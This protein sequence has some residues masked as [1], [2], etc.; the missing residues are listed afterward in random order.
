MRQKTLT[1]HQKKALDEYFQFLK[2]YPYCASN[3]EL[4]PIIR[5]PDILKQY[6]AETGIVIGMAAQTPYVDFIVDLVQPTQPQGTPPFPYLRLLYPKQLAGGVNVVVLATI[7]NSAVGKI[8]EIVIVE[9][10][11]HA[12]GKL[13]LELPRGFAESMLPGEVAAVKELREETGYIAET[14]KLLGTTFTDTGI[15]DAQVS[16]Y[17]ASVI[18]KERAQPEVTES[19]I[20]TITVATDELW[21]MIRRQEVTDGFTVQALALWAQAGES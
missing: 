19:I 9:Q 15:S 1:T 16:F 18:G 3:R 8:G 14:T 10:E 4:R 7:E 12:T 17:H 2:K 5:D 11:R 20:R 6:A 21:R 13:H